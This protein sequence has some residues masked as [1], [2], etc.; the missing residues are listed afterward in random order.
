MQTKHSVFVFT[1]R[2][3]NNVVE[4]SFSLYV[5]KMVFLFIVVVVVVFLSFYISFY[6]SIP[7]RF[8]KII[9]TNNSIW[10]SMEKWPSLSFLFH[11]NSVQTQTN[12]N[13]KYYADLTFVYKFMYFADI[14]F[15]FFCGDLLS[16]C[17]S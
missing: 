12:I 14:F 10:I 1:C 17:P 5:C 2:Q 16:A 8:P 4:R 3:W 6:T 9:E 11:S 13:R 7:Q 15:V